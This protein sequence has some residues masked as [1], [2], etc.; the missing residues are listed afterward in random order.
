[1]ISDVTDKKGN[2]VSE[3]IPFQ[4]PETSD[5]VLKKKMTFIKSFLILY[6]RSFYE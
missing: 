3:G 1:L 2:P 4:Y 6:W 5:F